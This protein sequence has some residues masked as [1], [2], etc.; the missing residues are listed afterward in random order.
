VEVGLLQV[1]LDQTPE[2]RVVALDVEHAT[3]A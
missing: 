1:W 3:T 2:K